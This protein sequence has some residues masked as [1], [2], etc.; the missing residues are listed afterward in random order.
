MYMKSI[1]K[2]PGAWL[3]LVMSLAALSLV[4]GYIALFGIVRQ[5]DGQ[6]DEGAAARIFQLLIAAQLPV[7][8]YFAIKWLPR[9][10]KEALAVLALQ[11]LAIASALTPIIL[12]ER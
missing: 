11:A 12:L 2:Q 4:A 7:A 6:A 3:P 10:P 1:L 8:G 5:S 9:R